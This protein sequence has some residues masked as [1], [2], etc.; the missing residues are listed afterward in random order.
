MRSERAEMAFSPLGCGRQL[1]HSD[2][3]SCR[4]SLYLGAGRGGHQPCCE[5][6]AGKE[7]ATCSRAPGPLPLLRSLAPSPPPSHP[8]HSDLAP[9]SPP[10]G[11]PSQ[12]RL[13]TPSR[14]LKALLGTQ[15]ALVTHPQRRESPM[16]SCISRGQGAP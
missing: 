2:S 13:E 3:G 5:A 10:L 7:P 16:D 8:R 12:V 14:P 1:L 6:E 11:P 9:G 15:T 4:K